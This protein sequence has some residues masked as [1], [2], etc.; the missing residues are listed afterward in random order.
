MTSQETNNFDDL[1]SLYQIAKEMGVLIGGIE[2]F[3]LKNIKT[4]V[5][6]QAI[7]LSFFIILIFEQ[8]LFF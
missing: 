6:F 1:F 4:R 3:L 5:T 2:E 8:N 7:L